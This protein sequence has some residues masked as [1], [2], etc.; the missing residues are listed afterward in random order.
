MCVF[1]RYFY[2]ESRRRNSATI[3]W[4][5]LTHLNSDGDFQSPKQFT[6][7]S[8]GRNNEEPNEN[9]KTRELRFLAKQ[10]FGAKKGERILNEDWSIWGIEYLEETGTG[11]AKTRP[12][13]RHTQIRNRSHRKTEG[14]V[15][16]KG[17]GMENWQEMAGTLGQEVE[18]W[19]E[20]CFVP[21]LLFPDCSPKCIS[22]G[23]KQLEEQ[24]DASGWRF[25]VRWKC[26]WDKDYRLSHH[27]RW[28]WVKGGDWRLLGR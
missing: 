19:M 16:G 28:N 26:W 23:K 5:R 18:T 4:V 17:N 6:N 27:Q 24:K 1:R 22:E 8:K 12:R 15:K 14:A 21:E 7:S 10:H 11:E 13:G 20:H 2:L 25:K 3:P 9:I